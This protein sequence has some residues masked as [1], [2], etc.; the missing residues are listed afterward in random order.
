MIYK[1]EQPEV[2][3]KPN[4]LIY[5]KNPYLLQHAYNPVDWYPWGQEAFEKAKKED[6]PIFLSIGYST[7]HWC[8]VMERESYDDEE[9]ARLINDAF[10]SIKV[11]REERPDID[12]TYMRACQA[13]IG[14][15]GWPLNIILTPDKKPFF[16]ATYIPKESIFGRTGMLE[17]IPRIKDL[18]EKN[19]DEV[20]K[21][22]MKVTSSIREVYRGKPG[23]ELDKD[24]FNMAYEQLLTMFDEQHGGF[25]DAPKFPT[26]HNLQFLLRY[27]RRTRDIIALRMVERT[28]TGMRMGGIYDHIGFGFHRYSTDSKWLV[29]HFEKMLYDQALIAMAYIEAYQATKDEEY[30]RAAREIFTYVLRD[31]TSPEGGFYSGED[32]D[33]EGV[34]GKFY[35]WTENEIR[36]VLGEESDLVKRIF[37][38]EEEGNFREEGRL[39]GKN[40][41][42]LTGSLSEIASDLKVPVDKLQK[43]LDDA[44]L[45]LF[46]ARE[47]R[48][49]P[50]KDDK[51]LV[52][53][54]GFMI[55]ALSK[56]AQVFNEPAYADAAQRAAD[57][58]LE[59][60]HDS[61]GRLYHRYR[62][63][64]LAVP[65]FL[66]DYTSLIWGLIE[67][68]ET[69]FKVRYLQTALDLTTDQI[70]H[71]WDN[72]HLGFYL[73]A[74]DAE[75]VIV[76][77]KQIYDGALPSGNS[78]AMLNLLRLGRMTAN[79][80]L[81][82]MAMQIGQAFSHSIQQVPS[83]YT[84]FM[85]ALDFAI[86]PASEVV[87]TGDSQ[88]N[89]TKA[90][91][92]ALR[93][94]FIPDKIVV[95]RP[96]EIE[97]PEII[98]LVEYTRYLSSTDGR[99]TAYV[100]QNYSCKLPTTDTGKMLEL[101]TT[102]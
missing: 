76:R 45:K 61:R 22:A 60:M 97:L 85:V 33:S 86:G 65:A 102:P 30:G 3:R 41:L 8:H 13:L 32:A 46:T 57:F 64:E 96:G 72:E 24:V 83:G 17:L 28:L 81:E 54:N 44:R 43:L 16:A 48:I 29:P 74:D 42:H 55:A 15:G 63:G 79:P 93:Q 84:Q 2:E 34:E 37:N 40:I 62:D 5:E 58:I 1:T 101:L 92:A 21:T 9:V 71:F 89:D 19:R 38:I 66:D 70:T 14:S 7:C 36:T 53:W 39:T 50:G 59:N 23:E 26:P 47:R 78:V 18:W 51:I 68:Y 98:R 95:F 100:C 31:M 69:T 56:G 87:I 91:L 27:W 75:E 94:E 35:V 88:A 73:T 67:L 80:E 49:H 25:D 4:R 6:K 90:M 77:K 10:V 99:A 11:D 12:S 20:E 52:D 82:M